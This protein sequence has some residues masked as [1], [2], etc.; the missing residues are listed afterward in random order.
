MK[1]G[2]LLFELTFADLLEVRTIF[3][4]RVSLLGSRFP[5]DLG[6]RDE[7]GVR[8]CVVRQSYSG[9]TPLSLSFGPLDSFKVGSSFYRS[10]ARLDT[11][12]ACAPSMIKLGLRVSRHK[13]SGV[14]FAV[15]FWNP[16]T[17]CVLD[18]LSGL[19][20]ADF[21]TVTSSRLQAI[22]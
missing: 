8:A 14:S 21:T 9:N 6:T 3:H 18:D 20:C 17:G 11:F 5:M 4:V 13:A 15:A 12:D 2:D 7:V 1:I 22:T 10:G 19:Q 16:F